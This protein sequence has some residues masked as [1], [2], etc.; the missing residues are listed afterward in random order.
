MSGV[1]GYVRSSASGF[2]HVADHLVRWN[3]IWRTADIAIGTQQHIQRFAA[4]L[5]LLDIG[6][7]EV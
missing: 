5:M 3:E 2:Q 7:S 1:A 4:D 6:T